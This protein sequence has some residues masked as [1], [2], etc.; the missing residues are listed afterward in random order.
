M[1]IGG[2][3]EFDGSFAGEG[4]VFEVRG[5]FEVVAGGVDG[6]GEEDAP[7]G[8]VGRG[9]CHGLLLY[10]CDLSLRMLAVLGK[11]RFWLTGGDLTLHTS[12]MYDNKNKKHLGELLAITNNIIQ[13]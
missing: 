3:R 4:E 2:C 9:G 11:N 5:E 8:F 12:A 13:T 7:C 6:G 1:E 10:Y